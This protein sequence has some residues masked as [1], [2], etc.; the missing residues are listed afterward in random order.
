MKYSQSSGP[1]FP[2][3]LVGTEGLQPTYTYVLLC[4]FLF[5]FFVEEGEGGG[6]LKDIFLELLYLKYN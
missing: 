4:F 5:F 1:F 6:D 2:T 3:H